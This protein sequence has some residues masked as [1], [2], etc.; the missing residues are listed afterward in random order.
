MRPAPHL[1]PQPWGWASPLFCP[2]RPGLWL[3]PFPTDPTAQPG[4]LRAPRGLSRRG[5]TEHLRPTRRNAKSALCPT[6]PAFA[7]EGSCVLRGHGGDARAGLRR[8]QEQLPHP[9]NHRA[10]VWVESGCPE[11]A[12]A[13]VRLPVRT[14]ILPFSAFSGLGGPAA[15]AQTEVNGLG[16]N[17]GCSPSCLCGLG[18]W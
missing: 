7:V 14:Q 4:R 2:R 1:S 17:T 8:V 13:S 18:Q 15:R 6:L 12:V 5:N 3:S 10:D 11:P 9:L 16:A